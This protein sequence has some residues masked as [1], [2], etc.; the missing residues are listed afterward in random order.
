MTV[1]LGD[2]LCCMAV[3]VGDKVPVAASQPHKWKQLLAGTVK[4]AQRILTEHQGL[5]ILAKLWETEDLDGC[6]TM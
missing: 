4:Q 3:Y 2:K 6:S 1:R 5:W